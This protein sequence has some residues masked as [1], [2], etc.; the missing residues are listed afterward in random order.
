[1]AYSS[2]RRRPLGSSGVDGKTA[3]ES[4]RPIGPMSGARVPL[5]ERQ[6]KTNRQESDLKMARALFRD[7]GMV[8][9]CKGISKA[10][11]GCIGMIVASRT[12]VDGRRLPYCRW[13]EITRLFEWFEG[14]WTHRPERRSC[15]N[16]I[17]RET[18]PEFRKSLRKLRR[19]VA[20]VRIRL[21]SNDCQCSRLRKRTMTA[22]KP[23]PQ[24][25]SRAFSFAASGGRCP[26]TRTTQSTKRLKRLPSL[27]DV[28][29]LSSVVFSS[30]RPPHKWKATVSLVAV[31]RRQSS[32]APSSWPTQCSQL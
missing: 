18:F 5:G 22:A 7:G 25:P 31:S 24:R 3:T 20:G 23:S 30:A 16:S 19:P 17:E 11:D 2:L 26:R 9:E 4:A 28:R 29:A 1:M 10:I 15:R 14:D 32:L 27:S 21:Y 8:G 13:S 6:T 12:T